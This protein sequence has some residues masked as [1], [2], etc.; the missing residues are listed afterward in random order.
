MGCQCYAL[1][2]I[3][4]GNA[5]AGDDGAGPAVVEALRARLGEVPG[6]LLE[7]L[8]GDLFAV[9]DLLPRVQ[10][11]IFVDAVIAQP[12]G[13]ILRRVP[14]SPGL[15]PSLHQTD[16]GAVM[17]ALAALDLVH[18]FPQWEVW[19][20]AIEPPRELKEELSPPVAQAVAELAEELA[21]RLAPHRKDPD[22]CPARGE[23]MGSA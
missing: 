14:P 23:G 13:A 3:G 16:I 4:I 21:A 5:L 17:R 10:R 8:D 18:P 20:I 12:P 6:V 9:A 19:G 11:L 15:A 1:A 22:R 7:S 2:V